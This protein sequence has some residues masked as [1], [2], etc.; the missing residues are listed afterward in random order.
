MLR[1][2]VDT[3]VL[4]DCWAFDDPVARPL[5]RA[6]DSGRIVCLRSADTDAELVDVL[7]RPVFAARFAARAV[8]AAALIARW[9]ALALPIARIFSAPWGCTDPQDQKFLDLAVSAR[10]D[11]LVSKDK[12]LL[13]L[14]RR[15]RR[16]GLAIIPVSAAVERVAAVARDAGSRPL[17]T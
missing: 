10:A 15:A 11:L 17:H 3:N 7:N 14:A 12:A 9:N 6:I 8:D 5:W 2:V 16:D 1:L 13:R 4:L